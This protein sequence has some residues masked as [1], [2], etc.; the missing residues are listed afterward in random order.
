MGTSP[1]TC[2]VVGTY[3]PAGGPAAA[4]TVAAVRRAW[5]DGREVVVVSPRPGAAPL[6]MPVAGAAVGR[7]ISRLRRRPDVRIVRII[8]PGLGQTLFAWNPG[9]P[10]GRG[11]RP[12]PGPPIPPADLKRTARALAAALSGFDQAELVV[13]GHLGVPGDVLALLWPA[14]ERVTANSEDVAEWL[15]AAGAP[16]VSVVEPYAGSGLRPPAGAAPSAGLETGFAGAV[17]PLEPAEWLLVTRGRR[18]LGRT[19]RRVLGPRTP[20]VRASLQQAWSRARRSL[21]RGP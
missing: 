9:G 14:V 3:P 10:S 16:G 13:T 17:S 11:R 8:R 21:S 15:G 2:L 12:D 6:V 4:A 19:A 7:A 1:R 5:A 18:L 20:A